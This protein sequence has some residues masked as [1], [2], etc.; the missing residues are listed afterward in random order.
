M[1]WKGIGCLHDGLW[2]SFL[3]SVASSSTDLMS[4]RCRRVADAVVGSNEGKKHSGLGP[5]TTYQHNPGS[6]STAVVGK[7]ADEENLGL[8]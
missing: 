3:D 5:K 6:V 1:I 8:T 4:S 2:K 7:V